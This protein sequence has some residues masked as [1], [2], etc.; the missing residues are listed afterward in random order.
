MENLNVNAN[1]AKFIDGNW[2]NI[3]LFKATEYEY[4]FMW[5]YVQTRGRFGTAIDCGAHCGVY[6]YL[7]SKQFDQVHSFEVEPTMRNILTSNISNAGC[8]NVTIHD[9]G[10]GEVC[11]TVN[12]IPGWHWH[13]NWHKQFDNKLLRITATS[14]S[15]HVLP[16][17]EK[18]EKS[19]VS[20]I[21]SIDSY[22]FTNVDLIKLD[23]EGYETKVVLGALDTIKRCNPII[24]CEQHARHPP[25]RYG[26]DQTALDILLELGYNIESKLFTNPHKYDY[27]LERR[28]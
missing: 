1:F 24:V 8:T 21:K 25:T 2:S 18:H 11:R 14:L 3:R 26:S 12:V 7:L 27:I 22:N 19:E 6:S 20:E 16:D 9:C 10:V 15:T 28:L 17:N 13:W 4:K 5:K 23:V